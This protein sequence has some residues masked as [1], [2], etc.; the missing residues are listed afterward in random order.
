M[1][2]TFSPRTVVQAIEEAAKS[3]QTATASSTRAVGRAVLLPRGH[4]AGERSLRRRAPGARP[5]EGRSRRAHPA[6]QRRLRVRVPRRHCARASSRCRSTRPRASASS[7]LP[8]QHAAHRR[9]A[10][11]R[12]ARHHAEIR[13]LL[14][15]VQ[16]K[17]PELAAGLRRRDAQ[18]AARG[19]Q[20]G[21]G[22]ARRRLLPPVHERLHLAP[23]GRHAHPRATSR[24]TCTSIMD[25]GLGSRR[26]DAASRG[27]RSTTTWA[28]S[29]S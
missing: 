22:R 19:A 23:E 8:R 21:Q 14:G 28:S 7:R 25:S 17:A 10:A 27:C 4:R 2:S 1:S 26:L 9:Q 24:P 16:S 11:A 6:R 13:R 5:E 18:G 29:A 15:T 3:T 12:D 20:A